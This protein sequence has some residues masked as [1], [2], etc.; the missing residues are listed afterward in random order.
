M[1]QVECVADQESRSVVGHA[2]RSTEL[3][4]CE[5]RDRRRAVAAERHPSL[6]SGQCGGVLEDS[7]QVGPMG[8]RCKLLCVGEVADPAHVT[9]AVKGRLSAEIGDGPIEHVFDSS[10]DSDMMGAMLS[11]STGCR[12]GSIAVMSG[13]PK[14]R[15]AGQRIGR[16]RVCAPCCT[17]AAR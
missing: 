8:G 15:Q 12:G 6:G 5:L 16:S 7:V 3:G 14:G 4:G 11:F 9:D 1:A 10:T 2:E 17:F 13:R